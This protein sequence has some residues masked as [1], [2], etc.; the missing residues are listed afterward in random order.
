MLVR[1]PSAGEQVKPTIR[2]VK[3]RIAGEGMLLHQARS[4]ES[5]LGYATVQSCTCAAL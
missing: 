5:A 4:P 3:Q 1:M 2:D